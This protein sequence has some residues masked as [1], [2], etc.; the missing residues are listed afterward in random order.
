MGQYDGVLMTEFPD[1]VSCA[2]RH[3]RVAQLRRDYPNITRFSGEPVE[4]NCRG[5]LETNAATR[6]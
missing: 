5:Q 1:D 4:R 2:P 3:A 6:G